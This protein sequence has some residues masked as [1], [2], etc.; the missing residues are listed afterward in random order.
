MRPS[1]RARPGASEMELQMGPLIDAVFLLLT[2]FLF[3][4]TLTTIEGLLPAQLALGN[5]E[6]QQE[7]PPEDTESVIVRVVQTGAEVQYFIDDW[8]VTD[9]A[10]VVSHL[11]DADKSSVVVIDAGPNVTYDYVVRL[12]NE[13]LRLAFGQIVFPLDAGS[14]GPLGGAERS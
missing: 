10:Q 6:Q 7:K 8:P 14:A 9:Y 3:T 12:Y 1:H 11:S 13:C 4:I 5:N 2:Y